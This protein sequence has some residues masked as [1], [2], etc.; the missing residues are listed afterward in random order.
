[1]TVT[2]RKVLFNRKLK[3]RIQTEGYL[4]ATF[5]PARNIS[6]MESSMKIYKGMHPNDQSN[7]YFRTVM[8]KQFCFFSYLMKQ[9]SP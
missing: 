4:L 6:S 2:A 8:W 9:R 7:N 3:L 1:V 5:A